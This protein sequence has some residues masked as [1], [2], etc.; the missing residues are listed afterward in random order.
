MKV[1]QEYRKIHLKTNM[2]RNSQKWFQCVY[3]FFDNFAMQNF[4]KVKN[5]SS[6]YMTFLKFQESHIHTGTIFDFFEIIKKVIY[7]LEPFLT[8]SLHIYMY[9]YIYIYMYMYIYMYIYIYVYV[10]IY[11]CI[12][13]YVYVA[14]RFSNPRKESTPCDGDGKRK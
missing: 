5:G 10:Y 3:D 9:M 7:T 13:I 12:Y 11:I 2:Q 1:Q 4:K 8:V 14:K 6:V